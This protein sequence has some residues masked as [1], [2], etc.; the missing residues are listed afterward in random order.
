MGVKVRGAKET[1]RSLRALAQ[2]VS[3]PAN[4]ASR[5]ALREMLA[6]AKA[7]APVLTGT[8]R[9]SLVIR[10][11]RRSPKLAPQHSIGVSP[12]VTGP[13]GERP[14]KYAH[15]VEFGLGPNRA[16]RFLTTAF[17]AAKSAVPKRFAEALVPAIEARAQRLANKIAR[18]R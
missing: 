2:F 4:E 12:R 6:L 11:D 8:L 18:G 7:G 5:H 1:A 3:V 16:S 9:K 17:E 14:I 15:L 13:N 10:R